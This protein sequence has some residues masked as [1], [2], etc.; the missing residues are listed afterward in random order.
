MP[1]G[2]SSVIGVRPAVIKIGTCERAAVMMPQAAFAVPTVTWTITACGRP[3]ASQAPCAMPTATDSCGTT[4]GRGARLP[5]ASRRAKAS[6]SVAKSVPA[7]ARK[8][9]TP[10]SSSRS[11]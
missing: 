11:R 3:V 5:S 7:L 1:G 2:P 9:S 8:K 6:T 4:M 10:R